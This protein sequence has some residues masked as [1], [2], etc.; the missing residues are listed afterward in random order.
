[1][2]FDSDIKKF[3]KKTGLKA[4]D[5]VR[6]IAFDVYGGIVRKTPVDTGRAKGNWQI[7]VGS[8]ATDAIDR[9]DTTKLGSANQAQFSDAQSAV[10]GYKGRGDI[11]IRN[12][13]EYIVGLEYG[14][15]KQAPAGMVRVTVAKWK[16]FLRDAVLE[17]K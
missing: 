8:P 4:D 7:S 16:K 13:V 11:I 6:K 14:T 10:N 9:T 5:V 15:S 2:S 12:N 1:M 3:I 17:V